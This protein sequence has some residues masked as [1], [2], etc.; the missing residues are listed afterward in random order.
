MSDST[1]YTATTIGPIYDT[2]RLTSSPAGLWAASY[3]FSHISYRLCGMIVDRGLVTSEYDILSPYF[4]K[5]DITIDGIGRYHDR[6]IFQPADPYTVLQEIS[7]L[8]DDIVGEI[9]EV[10]DETPTE[11]FKQYLQL[12]AI[13]FQSNGNPLCDCS[14]Y[15][16]AIE[17]ERTFPA[18]GDNP[19]ADMLDSRDKDR[20]IKIRN[21]ICKAFSGDKWPFP[22]RECLPY[23]EDITGRSIETERPRRKINSYYAIVQ[24]DGD[25]L[26]KYI[27]SIPKDEIRNFSKKCLE[28][29]SASAELVKTYGG[30]PIYAGGD[31]LLFIAPLTGNINNA[32]GNILDL[33]VGLREIFEK[34]EF[35]GKDKSILTLSV[36][37]VIRYYKYPLYEAF[38]EALKQLFVVAKK[39]RNAAAISL[40]KHSGKAVEF[41]LEDFNGSEQ[42]RRVQ[43]LL[44]QSQ[45]GEVPSSIRTKL[46]EYRPLF[47][48]AL[49]IGGNSLD[50]VF[51]NI[52][53]SDIHKNYQGIL[54]KI[55]ALMGSVS[56][57]EEEKFNLLDSLLRFSK[58]WREE[59]DD[60]D[61]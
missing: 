12:H 32:A 47:E 54:D 30:I 31:D 28:Y 18:W 22:K 61:V 42:T 5:S 4:S 8:F 10:F 16:D 37:V 57:N 58:F 40:Q 44:W 45:N 43:S 50:N 29:C 3:I 21:K 17:L 59:G 60:A 35:F 46:M 1:F 9:A 25:K 27:T 23:M 52:F 19:L 41:I 53:D 15:L 20:N 24:T 48:R 55:Q 6:I 49:T 26:G 14:Q 39:K 11:W 33:L 36:G 13:K 2:T 7:K 51:E 34:D 56:G 38:D